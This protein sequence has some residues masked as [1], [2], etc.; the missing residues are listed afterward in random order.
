MEWDDPKVEVLDRMAFGMC[1][2]LL[3]YSGLG[4]YFNWKTKAFKYYQL[5]D[6][7]GL[8]FGQFTVNFCRN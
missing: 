8:K 2:N 4:L 3:G 6:G 7:D 1:D 5:L